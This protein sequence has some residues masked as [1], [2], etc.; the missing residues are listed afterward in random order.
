MSLRP[1]RGVDVGPDTRCDHYDSE[2]DV[3]AFRFACCDAYYPC[4]QCHDAVTDH[5]AVPWPEHQFD[6]PSVR[7]GVCDTTLTVPD[8]LDC[9]YECPNCDAPFNPG[10]AAHAELYFE[11]DGE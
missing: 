1:I 5:E 8:Y 11:T 9:A 4:F 3:V 2:L 7:C 6:E 10:C